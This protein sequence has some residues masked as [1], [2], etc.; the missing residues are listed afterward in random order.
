ME[1]LKAK[2]IS[3]RYSEK[4]VI[5]NVSLSLCEGEI[6]AILGVSGAGK[7]TLFQILSGLISPTEGSVTLR[8]KDITGKSG[9]LS[10]MLQKDLLL[11]H[12]TIEDNVALPL[13]LSGE[14]KDSARKKVREHFSE[15]GIDGCEKKYPAE[16]SGGMRQRAA[17]LR[18]YMCGNEVALLDE[19]FSA[20]DAITRTKLHYWY[21]NLIKKEGHGQSMSSVIFITHDIDEAIFLADRVLIMSQKP[22]TIT[23][24]YETPKR[25]ATKDYLLSDEVIELKRQILK[26]L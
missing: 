14:S 22:G 7:T 20:L 9:L 15:F 5:E 24:E 1:L 16:L 13:I 8:D 26:S 18:T 21:L 25:S 2:N 6:V 19:P 10:Y 11:E 17:L 3:H 23:A 4:N 12:K